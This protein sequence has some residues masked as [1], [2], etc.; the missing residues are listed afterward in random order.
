MS[1]ALNMVNSEDIQSRLPPPPPPGK[2]RS[3]CFSFADT[4]RYNSYFLYI[5]FIIYKYLTFLINWPFFDYVYRPTLFW[6]YI[7]YPKL[8]DL[9]YILKLCLISHCLNKKLQTPTCN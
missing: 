9:S 6:K 7:I 8:I 2:M 1:M 3:R 4:T 5:I